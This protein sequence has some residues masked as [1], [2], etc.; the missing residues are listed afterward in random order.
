MLKCNDIH[1]L[2]LMTGGHH[3][4]TVKVRY[5]AKSIGLAFTHR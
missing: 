3:I 2:V 5:I 4:G 1:A